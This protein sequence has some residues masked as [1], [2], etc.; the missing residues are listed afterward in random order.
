MNQPRRRTHL[1]PSR[2]AR[3]CRDEDRSVQRRRLVL[4]R[5]R[6]DRCRL[7]RPARAI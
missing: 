3:L 4:H 7:A 5:R 6:R 1:P 2:H